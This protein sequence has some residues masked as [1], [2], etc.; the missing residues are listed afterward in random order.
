MGRRLALLQERLEAHQILVQG[1][2]GVG[3]EERR[4]HVPERPAGRVVRHLDVEAR[5]PL[6]TLLEAHDS[7]ILHPGAGQAAPRQDLV[8]HQLGDLAVPRHGDPRRTG[9]HPVEAALAGPA[10]LF[11][12]RH[13]PRKALEVGEQ[14][15]HLAHRRAHR[16]RLVEIDRPHTGADAEHAPER[17]VGDVPREDERAR[18]RHRRAGA[19][20]ARESPHDE[21]ASQHAQRQAPERRPARRGELAWAPLTLQGRDR[22]VAGVDGELVVHGGHAGHPVH[23]GQQNPSPRRRGPARAA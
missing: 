7:G 10:H 1:V 20:A 9:R 12:V 5:C 17:P 13:E 15:E 4:H 23:A 3:S 11:H 2:L 16:E 19:T 21:P 22:L 6:R 18:A 8:R 14:G